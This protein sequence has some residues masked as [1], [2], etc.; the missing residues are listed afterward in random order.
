[1]VRRVFRTIAYLGVFVVILVACN[2]STAE[3]YYN[4]GV[5]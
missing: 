3:S 4:Q 5:S 1:M 2:S